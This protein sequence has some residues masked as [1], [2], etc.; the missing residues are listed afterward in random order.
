MCS[1]R[2]QYIF[3]INIEIYQINRGKIKDI[4]NI[5]FLKRSTYL[6]NNYVLITKR[7]ISC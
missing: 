5:N 3:S 7:L 1:N 2:D 4:E 6:I